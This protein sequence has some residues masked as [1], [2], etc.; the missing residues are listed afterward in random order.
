MYRPSRLVTCPCGLN[1]SPRILETGP[2]RTGTVGPICAGAWGAAAGDCT[3]MGVA[4][5]SW[6]TAGTAAAAGPGAGTGAPEGATGPWAGT[7][8]VPAGRAAAACDEPTSACLGPCRR[9]T[10]GF[11]VGLGFTNCAL[12]RVLGLGFN[13]S[14]ALGTGLKIP[15]SSI[16]ASACLPAGL[17]VRENLFS[18]HVLWNV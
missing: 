3:S 13:P 7:L 6:G 12:G 17:H 8:G 14:I 1:G 18:S 5:V 9:N 15:P 16:S 11:R 2:R 10:K 4:A